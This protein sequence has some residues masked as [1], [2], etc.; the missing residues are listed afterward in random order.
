[1]SKTTV[2]KRSNGVSGEGGNTALPYFD[3]NTSA[4]VWN[5]GYVLAC[6]CHLG[7]RGREA[8]DFY[9]TEV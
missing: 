4:T 5:T 1:M 7:S 9:S 6:L 3:V 8:G 2:D